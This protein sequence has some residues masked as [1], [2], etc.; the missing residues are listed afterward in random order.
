MTLAM[1]RR[2]AKIR[3]RGAATLLLGSLLLGR[4]AFPLRGGDSLSGL[5][6]E[7]AAFARLRLIRTE[8]E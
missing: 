1:V 7:V 2:P 5:G 3:G 8:C 4:P 6:A